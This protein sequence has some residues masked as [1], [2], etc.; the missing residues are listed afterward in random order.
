MMNIAEVARTFEREA[1][2]DP[3]QAAADMQFLSEGVRNCILEQMK[4]HASDPA[5][6]AMLQVDRDRH[7]KLIAVHFIAADRLSA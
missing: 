6:Q 1:Q 3:R 5:R 7:G 2:R 4:V